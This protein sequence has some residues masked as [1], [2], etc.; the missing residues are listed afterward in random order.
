[1][2]IVRFHCVK[3]NQQTGPMSLFL[4]VVN[5]DLNGKL[6]IQYQNKV[7]IS[8]ISYLLNVATMCTVKL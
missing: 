6:L 8:F 1:M 5:S 2:V 3:L 4:N 7:S